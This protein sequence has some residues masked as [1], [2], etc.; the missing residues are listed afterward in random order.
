MSPRIRLTAVI[1]LAGLLPTV[2]LTLFIQLQV[3]DGLIESVCRGLAGLRTAS[4]AHLTT[5]L[6]E[7]ARELEAL[8]DERALADGLRRFATTPEDGGEHATADFLLPLCE[9]GG[10]DEVVLFDGTG[11]VL[12]R[13]AQDGG[14]LPG[15][16]SS[17]VQ[18]LLEQAIGSPGV[19]VSDVRRD[20]GAEPAL[21][22][23]R[24]LVPDGGGRTL[25]GLAVRFAPTALSE[26]LDQRE[27]LGMTGETYVVGAED[28]L[29]RSPSRFM[30]DA[31]LRIKLDHAA[32]QMAAAGETGVVVVMGADYHPQTVIS[33]YQPFAA[34][35]VRWLLLTEIDAAEVLEPAMALR[36][37][38][39]IILVMTAVFL[40]VSG[41][42]VVTRYLGALVGAGTIDDHALAEVLRRLEDVCGQIKEIRTLGRPSQP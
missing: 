29:M 22:M 3:T 33:A 25:G 42:I 5:W 2:S 23:V 8:M 10:Y 32:A 39:M 40:W 14:L 35:G 12:A 31:P 34:H 6:G 26:I 11:E 17:G 15:P 27:G 1:V 7:R 24:T 30:E 38:L 16:A 28:F 21:L 41:A 36:S 37:S 13:S 18:E 20:E 9:A 4:D 19:V